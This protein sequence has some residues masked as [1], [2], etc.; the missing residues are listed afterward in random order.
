MKLIEFLLAVESTKRETLALSV[1]YWNER[2]G[3]QPSMTAADVK[4]AFVQ[5]RVTKAKSVN[6]P[7]VLAKAGANV[8]VVGNADGGAKLWQLTET[9]RKLVRNLHG[10][11]DDQPEIEHS[12][13]DLNKVAAKIADSD[14]RAYIEEA[15]LCVSVGALRAAIVFI[16]VAAVADLKTRVWASG[17]DAVNAS[18]SN[19]NANAK[20][21]TSKNDLAKY[22][23]VELLL[24]AQDV[25]VIDKAQHTIL[26][27]ALDTR[28]QCGHPNRYQ[29][30]V[31]KVKSHI[32]D[33]AGV[34]WL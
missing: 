14:T 21:L 24:I 12:A 1:L 29:P 18:A 4:S 5:A 32:E 33:I 6:V 2:Y 22:R 7:D 10:L 8:D 17:K 28:N 9:G 27:Q 3:F 11:P 20:P 15:A 25:G 16:W 34:L 13:A 26:G 30:G 31:T 23:E 19:R